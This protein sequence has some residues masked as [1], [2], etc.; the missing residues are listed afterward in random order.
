M[1]T[2]HE[3]IRRTAEGKAVSDCTLNTELRLIPQQTITLDEY[4]RLGGMPLKTEV[5]TQ[6]PEIEQEMAEAN[7][8][9]TT[10]TGEEA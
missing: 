3:H 8:I 4:R 9:E 7:I 2:R 10:E 1:T 5:V 6:V